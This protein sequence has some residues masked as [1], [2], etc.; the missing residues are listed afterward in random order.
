MH[1][2]VGQ[3]AL[4][5]CSRSS[6]SLHEAPQNMSQSPEKH[7]ASK[8]SG[9]LASKGVKLLIGAGG[10]YASFLTLGKLH[11]Q[12][13]KYKNADGEKFTFAFFL[14]ATE[15]IANVLFAGV[16]LRFWGYQKGL[17]V[18]SFAKMGAAQVLAKACTSLA[19]ANAL[20][21]PVVSLA[22]SGKMV[23]VMLGS[24]LLGGKSYRLKEY[25]A[26]AAI[27]AGTAIVTIDQQKG[28]GEGKGKENSLIGV[29]FIVSSLALDGVVAGLQTG[30][31]SE[32]K[33]LLGEETKPFDFMFWTNMFMAWTALFFVLVPFDS[34]LS[35]KQPELLSGLAYCVQSP[36][37]A[38]KV[39]VY[40]LCSA[41]GQ[42]F[43]FYCIANFDPLTV[44]TITTS[45]KIL[46][47]LLSIFTENHSLSP[48]GWAG[49]VTAS[50]G[51]SMDVMEKTGGDHNHKEVKDKQ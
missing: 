16:A 36:D 19:L 50:V 46:S 25:L 15:A 7:L 18:N 30:I 5:S 42:S 22:K 9:L 49:V 17:P 45:R 27:L 43:I 20:S 2:H 37:M 35:F 21:F 44:T 48:L 11:E 3:W 39:A 38:W 31:K 8:P 12:I 34:S 1:V 47:T 32:T 26:V 13:F 51:I 10:I 40:S 41:V 14:Q 33:K 4:R 23:P 29:L 28:G 24:V 6:K